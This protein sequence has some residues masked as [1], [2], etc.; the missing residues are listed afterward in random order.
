MILRFAFGLLLSMFFAQG[1]RADDKI[2]AFVDIMAVTEKSEVYHLMTKASDY[3]SVQADLKINE[4]KSWSGM[5]DFFDAGQVIGSYSISKT[6]EYNQQQYTSR[7]GKLEQDFRGNRIS[8]SLSVS[9]GVSLGKVFSFRENQLDVK[10]GEVEV[11]AK[12]MSLAA[13][14]AQSYFSFLHLNGYSKMLKT[15][16]SSLRNLI[17]ESPSVSPSSRAT[18]N[19]S[20]SVSFDEPALTS[21][22]G[23]NQALNKIYQY[24]PD[25]ESVMGRRSEDFQK[26]VQ[27]E[28]AN[29]GT[30]GAQHFDYQ[31]ERIIELMMKLHSKAAD[32]LFKIPIDAKTAYEESSGNVARIESE[33]RENLAVNRWFIT[34]NS[35]GP[36]FAVNFTKSANNSRQMAHGEPT[37]I[38]GA[39]SFFT[40]SFA[41]NGGL[42]FRLVSNSLL[43]DAK[44]L[45]TKD[46]EK[47]VL[48]LFR[49]KYSDLDTLEKQFKVH[50][51]T[52]R[53]ILLQLMPIFEG[54]IDATTAIQIVSLFSSLSS[55]VNKIN[56][57]NTAMTNKRVEIL[58]LMGT[59]LEEVGNRDAN[60]EKSVKPKFK[61]RAK[62]KS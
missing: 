31:S 62:V 18:L 54:E 38:D 9:L 61:V 53:G 15:L 35:A 39:S 44:K 20:I 37:E 48:T 27:A 26:R 19:T 57:D 52:Y 60:A 17:A 40:V 3:E 34:M 41:L 12:R 29:Q 30:S 36:F 46:I 59:L 14:A 10:L 4:A 2:D 16:A 58:T 24:D 7:A 28:S 55:A 6:N 51:E 21:E 25:F 50:L 33:I 43:I 22:N 23:A 32:T 5:A 42:P 49:N 8:Q 11:H 45:Q 13:D 56:S 1:S 47:Q